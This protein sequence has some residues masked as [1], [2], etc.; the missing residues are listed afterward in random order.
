MTSGRNRN[1]A[2]SALLA[3]S[4]YDLEPQPEYRV[5]GIFRGV[6]TIR[7]KSYPVRIGS[8]SELLPGSLAIRTLEEKRYLVPLRYTG[9]TTLRGEALLSSYSAGPV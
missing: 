1:I 3:K 4:I 5:K 7:C 8:S 2:S 6:F 9:A